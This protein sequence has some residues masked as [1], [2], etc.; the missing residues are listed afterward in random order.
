MN[1]KFNLISEPWV[2]CVLLRDAKGSVTEFGLLDT[3]TKAH[4]VKEI[5][6]PSPLVTVALHRL[7]LAILHRN[8]GPAKASKWK[9][10]WDKGAFPAKPL[11]GYFK[12]WGSRFD[13]FDER[14]P[15]Y[16]DPRL[17]NDE[18]RPVN[19]LIHELAAGHNPTLFDH[20][21]EGSVPPLSFGLAARLVVAYQSFAVGGL[22]PRAGGGSVD[23][24]KQGPLMKA[25]VFIVQGNNLFETLMLNLIHYNLRD[26]FPCPGNTDKDKPAW[27]QNLRSEPKMRK[28]HGYVDY[29]TWQN[30]RIFLNVTSE[31]DA[32][33]GIV[34][35]RGDDLDA[36]SPVDQFETMCAFRKILKAKA[37]APPVIPVGFDEDRALWRDS[38]ALLETLGV[39][40]SSEEH[41]Y[42][43]PKTL[44]WLAD[45]VRGEYLDGKKRFGVA[46]LGLCADRAKLIFWRRESF[47]LPLAYLYDSEDP[48]PV[49]RLRRGLELAEETAH[50]LYA[51]NAFLARLVL[52]PDS[53]DRDKPQPDKNAVAQ[54]IKSFGA[55]RAYW[56]ALETP[57]RRM[58]VDI[59]Q[60]KDVAVERW[61]RV[62]GA[63]AELAFEQA[64]DAAGDSARALKAATKARGYLYGHLYSNK[65]DKNNQKFGVLADWV[66]EKKEVVDEK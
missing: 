15:F 21:A 58:L 33:L 47:P 8:F 39:K 34:L 48:G 32:V 12:E 14:R 37:G 18:P 2:P 23:A 16:Q 54:L 65:L 36:A 6:D 43:S 3:L 9:E 45:L 63:E 20:S 13:L 29:L 27:E 51:A 10:L 22:I 35:V 60:A 31:G 46:G 44:H 1:G 66:K 30:R 25:V 11:K 57:F 50:V 56:A 17:K 38:V 55:E 49:A 5:Y 28:P 4:E 61:A 41:F 62:I 53:D 19:S 42:E 52:A 40:G 24:A 26:S 64:A 59:P 7:L